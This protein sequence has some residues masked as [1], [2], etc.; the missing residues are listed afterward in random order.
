MSVSYLGSQPLH[1]DVSVQQR[2]LFPFSAGASMCSL[3]TASSGEVS[4]QILWGF[5]GMFLLSLIAVACSDSRAVSGRGC[6]LSSA[7]D[8]LIC[9]LL[10]IK[11]EYS[12]NSST[13]EQN[14]SKRLNVL[15]EEGSGEQNETKRYWCAVE[16]F[17]PF[18]FVV[19]LFVE[20]L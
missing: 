16:G 10:G 9:L 4:P 7:M 2:K 15:E 20:N 19:I 17:F 14:E 5:F 11:D 3:L 1:P 12:F 6:R 13:E 18:C 8:S